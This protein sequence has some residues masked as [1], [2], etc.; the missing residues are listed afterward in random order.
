[1]TSN[2]NCDIKIKWELEKI[3][4]DRENCKFKREIAWV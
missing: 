3:T 1:L 2:F 4:E